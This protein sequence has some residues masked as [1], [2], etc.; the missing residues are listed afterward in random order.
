MDAAASTY[1]SLTGS[2]HYIEYCHRMN[3][4]QSKFMKEEEYVNAILQIVGICSVLSRRHA[5]D[6]CSLHREKNL[7]NT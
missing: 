2:Q 7:T 6:I 5:Q 3:S 4:K 1:C